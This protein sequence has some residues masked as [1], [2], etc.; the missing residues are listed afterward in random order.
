MLQD[1]NSL[2][3]SSSILK[4]GDSGEDDWYKNIKAA[5]DESEAVISSLNLGSNIYYDNST[6]NSTNK[7]SFVVDSDDD[8][9]VKDI[10]F[11]NDQYHSLLGEL[12]ELKNC[13]VDL[14]KQYKTMKRRIGKAEQSIDEQLDYIYF[15]EREVARLD[16][17]GRRENLEIAGIPEYISDNEL[18]ANVLH[19]L[20]KIGVTHLDSYAIVGCHRLGKKLKN[21]CRNTI[22]RFLHRKDTISCL[23]SANRLHLCKDLGFTNL[24]IMEN[25]CPAYRSIF[26]SLS[27]L[28]RDGRIKKLWTFNGTVNFK[29]S[30]NINEKPNKVF[31][32]CDLNYFFCDK[33]YSNGWE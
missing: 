12:N 16:Q 22:V 19:I 32:E 28:K 29:F 33:N 2:N 5:N 6:D 3:D 13:N 25:L 9:H 23:K 11:S 15:L 26:D 17:Y 20:R 27:N 21:G 10:L 1:T 7:V 14:V 8:G 30:D 4:I 24:R 18:E 31:H